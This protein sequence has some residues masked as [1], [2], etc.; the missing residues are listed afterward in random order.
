M[1]V[2]DDL[3]RLAKLYGQSADLYDKKADELDKAVDVNAQKFIDR[4]TTGIN[5]KSLEDQDMLWNDQWNWNATTPSSTMADTSEAFSHENLK[6]GAPKDATNLDGM[7]AAARVANLNRDIAGLRRKQAD[8]VKKE[9]ASAFDTS[10]MIAKDIAS[11]DT[12][13]Q[14]VTVEGVDAQGNKVKTVTEAPK[15]QVAATED[16]K[17]VQPTGTQNLGISNMSEFET[18]WTDPNTGMRYD[19][20]GNP[21]FIEKATPGIA[22]GEEDI[23]TRVPNPSFQGGVPVPQEME[24]II[25]GGGEEL[26]YDAELIKAA[27]EAGAIEPTGEIAGDFIT[28]WEMANKPS[29]FDLTGVKEVEG[30]NKAATYENYKPQDQFEDAIQIIS[31]DGKPQGAGKGTGVGSQD[32]EGFW[33]GIRSWAAE[34]PEMAQM[35]GK[36]MATYI[37]TGDP[38]EAAGAGIEGALGGMDT[39]AKAREAAREEDLEMMDNY[40]ANSINKYRQTKNVE[41]LVK[42]GKAPEISGKPHGEREMTY[43]TKDGKKVTKTTPYWNTKQGV[44][45]QN[46]ITN[47]FIPAPQGF[48]AMP[49]SGNIQKQNTD[50]RNLANQ[51]AEKFN[52]M[53]AGIKD[54]DGHAIMPLKKDITGRIVESLRSLNKVYGINMANPNADEYVAITQGLEN[55]A[56]AQVARQQEMGSDFEFEY[57]INK[58]IQDMIIRER[59]IYEGGVNP[60]SFETADGEVNEE[61][62]AKAFNKIQNFI[63]RNKKQSVSLGEAFKIL[64]NEYLREWVQNDPDKVTAFEDKGIPGFIAFINTEANFV[65]E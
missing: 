5:A 18:A 4:Y 30:A 6:K 22:A 53:F 39:K 1:S 37:K 10:D 15:E 9:Q 48:T 14:K 52:K 25:K 29:Q 44:Y 57:N 27:R 49:D 7:D 60:G 13:T 43:A 47:Q 65:I 12:G 38:Y 11:K 20:L 23:V 28:E 31:K 42:I 2:F 16:K 19:G 50:I 56:D 35:I 36:G 63:S 33:D 55:W 45:V 62:T 21:E 46:P 3:E 54:S 58:Y 51:E 17:V 26:G 61:E 41:D 34:N 59:G 64:E 32:E 40:T 8:S 24:D